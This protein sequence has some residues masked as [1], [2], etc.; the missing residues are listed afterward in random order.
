M[1]KVYDSVGWD[2]LKKSLVRI[3][4]CNKFIQF[5]GNI[6]KGH[7]NWV[8]TDFGLT[9]DYHVHDNLD[10]ALCDTGFLNIL[11]F[12]DCVSICNHLSQVNASMLSVYI[13]RSLKNFGIVNCSAG[14]TAFFKDIGVSLGVGVID[15]MSFTLAKLQAIVL[16]LECV[17]LSSSVHL[18]L[19]N[20]SALDA[21]K[22]ELGLVISDFC[23]QYWIERRHIFNIIHSKNL[24]I[25]WHKVKG[26]SGV[27]GNKC[28]D[29]IAGTASLLGWCLPLHVDKHFIVADSNIVSGNFRYFVCDI[30]Y[31][32]CHTRWEVG[33]GC[34]FLETCLL[35]EINW[36]CSS[37][38]WHPDLHMVTGFTSRPSAYAHTYFIKTL[39]YHLSVAVWKHLYNRLYPS[40]LCLY[41]SQVEVLDYAFSCKVNKFAYCQLLDSHVDS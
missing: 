32:V 22:S 5:F 31:F 7:T 38:V 21:C 27:L 23:N 34:K 1:R 16:A 25:S 20:Q 40:V 29:M 36:V 6:H 12:S 35:S 19:D 37:L 11:E 3:K 17:L 14:A 13:D 15:L 39:H 9:D 18:F 4:M 2:H 26:H 30:F 28:A 8:M 33:S 10:Q 24:R 41:C